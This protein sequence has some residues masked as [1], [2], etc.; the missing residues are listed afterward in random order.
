M[1]RKMVVIF[2][3]FVLSLLPDVKSKS[4]NF[5]DYKLEFSNCTLCRGPKAK[6]LTELTVLLTKYDNGTYMIFHNITFFENIFLPEIKM[7]VHEL[8]GVKKSLLWIYKVTEAC[9]H[10]FFAEILSQHLNSSNC[11]IKKG[12]YSVEFNLNRL[13]RIFFG[14]SFYYG[15]YLLNLIIATKQGNILCLRYGEFKIEWKN[16][17]LCRGPKARNLSDIST[18]LN[19]YENGTN[20]LFM[21]VSLPNN[22]IIHEAKTLVHELH[23][24][25]KSLLWNYKV[26][27]A[28]KHFFFA[29]IIRRHLNSTDC[30]VQKGFYSIKFNLNQLISIFYGKSFYY[31]DYLFN[32]IIATRQGNILCL[33]YK[34]ICYSIVHLKKF[35]KKVRDGICLSLRDNPQ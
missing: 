3:I 17:T 10:F 34:I 18:A 29:Q 35:N 6:N 8:H 20:V 31:G 7:S 25:K 2:I 13:I 23:G 26:S 30:H 22:I 4:E 28:C 32:L 16:L 33:S 9:K 14:N 27:E 19:T 21:N 1:P 11:H 24:Q 12:F 5:G 15:E